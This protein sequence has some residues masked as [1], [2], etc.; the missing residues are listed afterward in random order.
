MNPNPMIESHIGLWWTDRAKAKLQAVCQPDEFHA[1]ER[2]CQFAI[3]HDIWN[4]ECYSTACMQLPKFI[5]A[6][7]PALTEQAV[8]KIAKMAAF[9]H[10]E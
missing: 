9:Q 5:K 2:I 1:I 10:R 6:E 4:Q 8:T 7:Y 3:S